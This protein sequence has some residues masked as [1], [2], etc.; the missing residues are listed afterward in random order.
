MFEI[1]DA[2]NRQFIPVPK[3][4]EVKIEGW[5]DLTF[6]IHRPIIRVGFINKRWQISE[7]T[8]GCGIGESQPTK[9]MA[10]EYVTQKLA[11]INTHEYRQ[12]IRGK[13]KELR[14]TGEEI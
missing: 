7:V 5:E 14:R 4:K 3:A 8:T 1:Y 12:I 2:T 6:F 11:K 10:I 13:A 9:A